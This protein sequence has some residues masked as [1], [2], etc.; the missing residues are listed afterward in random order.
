MKKSNDTMEDILTYLYC[1]A[2]TLALIRNEFDIGTSRIFCADALF[3]EIH[4]LRQ[5][6]GQL[7]KHI[8]QMPEEMLQQIADTVASNQ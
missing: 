6:C 1:T 3:G 4:H 5:L 2:D 7:S 8:K